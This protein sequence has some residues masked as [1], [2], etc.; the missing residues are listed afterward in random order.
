MKRRLILAIG[1]VMIVFV[2][3]ALNL[4]WFA[5]TPDFEGERTVKLPRGS[6][7][8]AVADSL[9]AAGI[10]QKRTGFLWWASLSGWGDQIKAG[11]YA[12]DAG[13]SNIDLVLKLR[14]GLQSP[15]RIQVPGGTRRERLI[16]GMAREMAF[17]EDELDAVLSDS[18]FAA[19]LG[20]DTT[21]LW[22]WMVPDSYDFYWL[23]D[24]EDVV[25]TVKGYADRS[26][27]AAIDTLG[28]L[29]RNYTPDE[30][31]RLAGIIEWETSHVAEK[32]TISGVYHNRLR[33]RWRL[34]ADPTVQYAIMLL[35]GN[36]RRLFFRD[37]RTDHPYNT[38][39]RGGLPPG[40]I[41]NPSLS[42]IE[43]AMTP[44]SHRYY[45]FVARGDGTHIFSRTLAEHRRR[46][47]EYSRV[48]QERRAEQARIEQAEQKA[49]PSSTE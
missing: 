8:V 32:R 40:P 42:S 38:Y 33:D 46:A 4:F 39:R 10:L 19:S 29:P 5:A 9:E 21:H 17:T 37:Y 14:Q 31:V 11:H 45:F 48:M 20:T 43:A 44:E 23:T 41:T 28:A 16:R 27:A 7:I 22:A 26:V 15:I 2:M 34:D 6:S 49:D 30:I 47:N 12:F 25:R 1:V 24:P 3:I 18:A 13:A 35:E 36:K